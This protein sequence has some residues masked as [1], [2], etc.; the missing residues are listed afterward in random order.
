MNNLF[1]LL[2]PCLLFPCLSLAQK[3]DEKKKNDRQYKMSTG[4]GIKGGINFAN[5]TNAS[6]INSSG[7]SG[8]HIGAFFSP[9]A[10][11]KRVL[12][13]R[14]EIVY[15]KQGYD[16]KKG[17]GFGSVHLDY[18]IMPHLLTFNISKYVQLQIGTHT[19]YLLNAK[20]D[21]AGTGGLQKVSNFFHNYDYG[22]AGGL[23]IH[24]FKGLIIGA[25]LN[26]SFSNLNKQNDG[27]SFPVFIP[28]VSNIHLRNNLLQIS[29]GYMF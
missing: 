1:K 22:F 12:G 18:I 15:S 3:K 21:T 23:E 4:I 6:S 26:Y 14:T 19:A 11:T 20:A 5:V 8:F 9:G 7:R 29:A 28:N 25:R 17:A 2:M 24:P 10:G 27:V 13:Y 16:Y